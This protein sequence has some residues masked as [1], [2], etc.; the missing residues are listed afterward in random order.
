MRRK[1]CD[2]YGYPLYEPEERVFVVCSADGRVFATMTGKDW[3]AVRRKLR[4]FI[5][6]AVNIGIVFHEVH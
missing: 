5:T 4:D 3:Q 1:G 6:E 2:I